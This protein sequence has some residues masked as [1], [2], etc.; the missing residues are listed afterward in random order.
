MDLDIQTAMMGS[1]REPQEFGF[2]PAQPLQ[3]GG[4]TG[5]YGY[6]GWLGWSSD[7]Q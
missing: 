6:P 3:G 7:A 4:T 1:D 5:Q 2:Y